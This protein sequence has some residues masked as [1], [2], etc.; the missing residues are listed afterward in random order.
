MGGAAST[1]A[2][3]GWEK[4]VATHPLDAADVPDDAADSDD[5][6]ASALR[7]LQSA[8]AAMVPDPGALADGAKV[9]TIAIQELSFCLNQSDER[10]ETRAFWLSQ[11]SAAGLWWWCLFRLTFF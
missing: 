10:N 1:T 8:E 6:V 11:N 9:C 4:Y 7:E 3:D 2:R 5:A